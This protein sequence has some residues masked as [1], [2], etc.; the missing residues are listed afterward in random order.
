VEFEH[1]VDKE[2]FAN[3]FYGCYEPLVKTM[4]SE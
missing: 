3:D 4:Q 1:S 2:R